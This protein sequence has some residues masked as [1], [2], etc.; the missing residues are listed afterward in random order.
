[1]FLPDPPTNGNL[2]KKKKE[3]GIGEQ[4]DVQL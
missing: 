1:M 4:G 2:K 3:I